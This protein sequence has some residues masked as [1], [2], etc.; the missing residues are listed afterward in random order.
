MAV[1]AGSRGSGWSQAAAPYQVAVGGERCRE[2]FV[3]VRRPMFERAFVRGDVVVAL[4]DDLVSRPPAYLTNAAK[5]LTVVTGGARRQDSVAAAFRAVST[6]ADVVV[7]HDAAR[8]FV[9]A[10]LIT[11]TIAAAAESGAALA[12]LEARDTVKTL[13]LAPSKVEVR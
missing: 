7:V 5:T 1:R 10:D 11:R 9:S 6:H 12:A 3:R 2:R 4:P 13:R 8:P